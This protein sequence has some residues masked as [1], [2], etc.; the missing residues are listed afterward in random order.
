MSTSNDR[1]I[2]LEV[3]TDKD[4]DAECIKTL[5]NSFLPYQFKLPQGI[6]C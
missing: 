3:F 1:P 2:L 6:Q 5:T 4:I